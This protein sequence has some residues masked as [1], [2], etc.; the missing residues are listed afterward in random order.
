MR[1]DLVESIGSRRVWTA[2]IRLTGRRG[3]LDESGKRWEINHMTEAAR[4][5]LDT[6]DALQEADCQE[7]LY[8]ILRRVALAPHQAPSDTELIAAADEVFLDLDRRET[9]S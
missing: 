3:E 7:V 4:K 8:E 5:L 9:Q 6:F 2:G 1:L